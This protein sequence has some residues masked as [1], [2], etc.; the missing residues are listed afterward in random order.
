[1]PRG[2]RR[3]R[4]GRKPGTPN[5]RTLEMT[6]IAKQAAAEGVTPAHVLAEAT[7]FHFRRYQEAEGDE[8]KA[9]HLARAQQAAKDFAPY[10]HPRIAQIEPQPADDGA[11]DT[12]DPYQGMS[13]M[14]FL[15]RLAFMLLKIPPK[16]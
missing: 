13:Q 16:E 15:R 9:V 1:M 4:A 2:G 14:E 3:E 7:R 10:A 8:V 6:A 5:K 12:A 11:D